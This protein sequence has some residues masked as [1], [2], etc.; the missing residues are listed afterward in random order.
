MR[1]NVIIGII[2][3]SYTVLNVASVFK[4]HINEIV[5]QPTDQNWSVGQ[6]SNDFCDYNEIQVNGL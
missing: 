1:Y 4:L 6:T 3:K 2:L 5:Y